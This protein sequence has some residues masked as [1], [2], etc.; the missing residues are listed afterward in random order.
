MWVSVCIYH[1]IRRENS[2][3]RLEIYS[4]GNSQKEE[5]DLFPQEDSPSA[6]W[7]TAPN[8]NIRRGGPFRVGHALNVHSCTL[9]NRTVNSGRNPHFRRQ[10]NQPFWAPLLVS[11]R[12]SSLLGETT[13]MSQF[14]CGYNGN[15]EFFLLSKL[16]IHLPIQAIYQRSSITRRNYVQQQEERI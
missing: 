2:T 13:R 15:Q 9:R 8:I 4:F 14:I 6:A 16:R 1:S 5:D 7:L 3:Q 11:H 12:S 10:P